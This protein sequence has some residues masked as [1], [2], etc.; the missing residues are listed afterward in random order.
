MPYPNTANTAG[1]TATEDS[2]SCAPCAAGQFKNVSG[3]GPCLHCKA[4]SVSA[5]GAVAVSECRCKQGF[6]DTGGHAS[7]APCA[8]GKF[9]GTVG[10]EACEACAAGEMSP[11]GST[12]PASCTGRCM[13]GSQGPDGGPCIECSAGFFKPNFGDGACAPCPAHSHSAPGSEVVDHCHCNQ[14]YS[15]R[16]I[17]GAEC[18]L[19][20][21]GHAYPVTLVLD[22]FMSMDAFTPATQ[23]T[24]I[25]ALAAAA[26]VL[27][28]DVSILA[29]APVSAESD[30]LRGRS[31]HRMEER[32]A[33]QENVRVDEDES[34]RIQVQVSFLVADAAAAADL[35]SRLTQEAITSALVTAGLPIAK[36]ITIT[37]ADSAPVAPS[38]SIQAV[39]ANSAEEDGDGAASS[40]WCAG[41]VC[42]PAA[43]VLGVAAAGFLTVA[44]MLCL[45]SFMLDLAW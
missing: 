31:A 15:R 21:S 34:K 42:F 38:S 11:A 19:K 20:Q 24:F 28:S 33:R 44:G 17:S 3:N 23:V 45:F 7:C 10:S 39:S 14:G 22:V 36:L 35:R 32:R 40:S 29:I 2:R 5:L 26:G 16:N 18:E 41:S 8:A 1:Y 25:S 43:V 4:N 6:T 12:S 9:K 37:S 13:P 30:F 27:V